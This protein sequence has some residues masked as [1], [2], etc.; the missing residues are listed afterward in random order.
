LNKVLFSY[1]HVF[2]LFLLFH[3]LVTLHLI[4]Y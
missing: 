1:M 4:I 2:L 3:L